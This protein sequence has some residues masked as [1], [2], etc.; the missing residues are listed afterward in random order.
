MLKQASSILESKK[1][2][3][4]GRSARPTLNNCKVIN[5]LVAILAI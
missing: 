4:V 1:K 5:N 2:E 3:I